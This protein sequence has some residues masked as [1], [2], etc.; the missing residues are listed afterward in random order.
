MNT[1]ANIVRL[2]ET[3]NLD[4]VLD[5]TRGV[6]AQA[7]ARQHYDVSMPL[8]QQGVDIIKE[9]AHIELSMAQLDRL[10]KLYPIQR[11]RII[12]SDFDSDAVSSLLTAVSQYFLGCDWPSFGEQVNFVK[13]IAAMQLAVPLMR[14]LL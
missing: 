7:L 5:L 4:A 11:A 6:R 14:P 13:Y 12:D 3:K 8:L 1:A 10:L 2:F 9:N